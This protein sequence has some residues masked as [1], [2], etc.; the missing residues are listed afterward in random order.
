MRLTFFAAG[1]LA[2]CASLAQAQ[3]RGAGEAQARFELGRDYR[4]GAGVP[5]DSVRAFALIQAAA[6]AGHAAAMFTLSNMLME[7][8]GVE[9]DETGARHWLEA[10]A[11]RDYPEAL[12]QLAFHLKEGS[13]GFGR[14]EGRAEQLLRAM[15]HAM[16]H[17]AHGH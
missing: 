2:M 16:K 7:G 12:Q 6:R 1:L 8:E 14:D 15:G 13:M 11:D 4:H 17:R 10:A 9:R 5:R 3:P